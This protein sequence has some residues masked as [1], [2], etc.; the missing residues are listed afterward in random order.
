MKEVD[1]HFNPPPLLFDVE[2]LNRDVFVNFRSC[3]SVIEAIPPLSQSNLADK[4]CKTT[5]RPRPLCR[6]CKGSICQPIGNR[7]HDTNGYLN[8][9]ALAVPKESSLIRFTDNGQ[10]VN[11]T[12]KDENKIFCS[13]IRFTRFMKCFI[14]N[15]YSSLFEIIYI[16]T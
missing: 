14:P 11:M 1:R 12:S 7:P 13:Y 5:T 9:Y 16:F 4:H 10:K 15:S 3:T 2:R 6:I 8:P